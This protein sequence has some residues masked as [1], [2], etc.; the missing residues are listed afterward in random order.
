MPAPDW[1]LHFL[2]LATSVL[3]VIAKSALP[4]KEK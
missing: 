4:L 3:M 1:M 2:P